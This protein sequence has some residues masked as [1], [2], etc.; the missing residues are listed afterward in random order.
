MFFAWI[1]SY[2][3]NLQR[4]YGMPSI[5]GFAWCR[6]VFLVCGR[7]LDRGICYGHA[8]SKASQKAVQLTRHALAPAACAGALMAGL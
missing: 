2:I 3:D 8:H 6:N 4:R 5:R 1:T 7:E